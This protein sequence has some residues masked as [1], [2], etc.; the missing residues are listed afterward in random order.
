M[1]EEKW[2]KIKIIHEKFNSLAPHDVP[3]HQALLYLIRNPII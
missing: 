1:L 3:L 2:P